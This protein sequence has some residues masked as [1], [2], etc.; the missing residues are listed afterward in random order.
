MLE[1]NEGLLDLYRKDYPKIS[2]YFFGIVQMDSLTNIGIFLER[3]LDLKEK[4]LFQK[5]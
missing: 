3:Q 4:F 5:R 2:S 1:Y